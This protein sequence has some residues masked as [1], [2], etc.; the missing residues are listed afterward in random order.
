MPV[1]KRNLIANYLGQGWMALMGMAFIPLYI[2][3]LGIGAWGVVAFVSSLQAWLLLVDMGLTPAVSREMARFTGGIYTAESIGGLLRAFELVC[4]S[5]GALVVAVGVLG[6][7]WITA[8]WLASPGG[9]ADRFA[10][11]LQISSV[12]LAGRVLEQGYRGALRG[13]QHQ[14]WL[15][16]ADSV[17]ATLRWG[18]AA[19][20]IMRWPTLEA[21]FGWQAFVS[22]LSVVALRWK[23]H[24][25]LG[26]PVKEARADFRMLWAIRHVSGGIGLITFLALLL[27]QIDKLLLSRLLTLEQYGAYMLAATV[28]G[29]LSFLVMPLTLAVAPRLAELVAR[30]DEAG[31]VQL[32]RQASQSVAAAIVPV[33][34]T[35]AVFAHEI[36]ALWTGNP[37]LAHE[38]APM[39]S[40]LALGTMF[41]A[42]MHV[43]YQTQLAYGWTSLAVKI[44]L[45]AVTLLVPAIAIFVPIYGA[46]AAAWIW[47]VLN[48]GYVAVGIRFMYKKLLQHEKNDWYRYGVVIPVAISAACLIGIKMTMPSYSP[49]PLAI[50]ATLFVGLSCS[51]VL[52]MTALP[53]LRQRVFDTFRTIRRLR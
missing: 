23:T 38:A 6:A 1:V 22:L 7:Q 26:S 11:A 41:N 43:P 14:V 36:L 5:A 31:V 44:N 10:T 37:T 39:L 29:G 25:V 49:N 13:L 9:Q 32:Y 2:E 52:T 20:V 18:G 15:N 48:V 33:A 51:M 8:N 4:L 27:T 17:L 45:A 24:H 34:M 40:L 50:V 19:V 53:I 21:F 16:A 42:F 3:Y 12:V 30:G 28:A 35:L 47:L 46:I